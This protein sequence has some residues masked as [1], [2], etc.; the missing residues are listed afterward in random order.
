[1]EADSLNQAT[2]IETAEPLDVQTPEMPTPE[3][4]GISI[5]AG[6][7]DAAGNVIPMV[8]T[9]G[10]TFEF[11]V[12]VGWSVNGSALLVM[13]V[14]SANAKGIAQLGVSQESSRMVKDGKEFSQI[15]F[16][17]KLVAQD[18][19]NLNVPVLK[20]E[21]PTPMGQPLEMRTESVPVRVD[22]PFNPLPI[23]AG[24]FIAFVVVATSLL[25]I[26]RRRNLASQISAK[27]AAEEAL[28]EKMLVLK[29]R[30]STAD[31]RGWLLDLETVCKEYAAEQFG[32]ATE[33][34]NLES[35]LKEGSLEGWEPLLE[36]FAHARYG[37]G[38]RDS[39]QNKET[40]K[41]A[42]KLMNVNED[43]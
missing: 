43:Q 10:D 37:G 36:E 1:M 28:L 25:R 31:S 14:S 9:V 30:V 6:V 33:S 16:N 38:N 35:M 24:V 5:S 13:P 15:T 8:L 26:R 18:T 19:G 20:F 12:T 2:E 39:Y 32:K 23:F 41:L 29:Q 42:M 17:Y 3:Q 34:V 11:P 22:S 40:W 7:K 4:L 27:Q 21:I